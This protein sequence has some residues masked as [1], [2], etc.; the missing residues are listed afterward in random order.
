M[1]FTFLRLGGAVNA[2]LFSNTLL[3]VTSVQ[4]SK[5]S[6]ALTQAYPLQADLGLFHSSCSRAVADHLI[7]LGLILGK[8]LLLML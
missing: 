1:G 2:V 7:T 6:V 8:L 4:I 5:R 3:K